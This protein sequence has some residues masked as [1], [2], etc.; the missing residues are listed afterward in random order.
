MPEPK[1]L[2]EKISAVFPEVS[3]VFSF[4]LQITFLLVTHA[5]ST[6]MKI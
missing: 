6:K 4:A 1:A 5:V 3:A 2:F